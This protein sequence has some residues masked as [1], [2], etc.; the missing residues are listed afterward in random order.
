MSFASILNNLGGKKGVETFLGFLEKIT[1]RFVKVAHAI[2]VRR[3]PRVDAK[4]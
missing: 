3:S 1:I 4:K 2:S